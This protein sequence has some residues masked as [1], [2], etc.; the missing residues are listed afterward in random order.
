VTSTAFPSRGARRSWALVG[1]AAV[2]AGL[3]LAACG[4]SGTDTTTGTAAANDQPPT[5]ESTTTTT[6]PRKPCTP[7]NLQSAAAA[8][9][10]NPTVED[11]TCSAT[12]AVATLMSS[13]GTQ[14][15]FFGTQADGSWVVLKVSALEADAAAEA[16]AGVPV[17]L[18]TG[19]RSRYDNRQQAAASAGSEPDYSQGDGAPPTTQPPPPPPEP[20]PEELPPELVPTDQPPAE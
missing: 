17:S 1:P 3:L 4:G 9:Y 19:W 6:A 5:T 7:S 10:R 18:A 14:L 16:P 8:Q 2:A 12:F 20:V 13:V 15:A 11:V